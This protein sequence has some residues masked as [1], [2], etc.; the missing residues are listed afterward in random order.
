VT[1]TETEPCPSSTESVPFPST[2]NVSNG[3][4]SN[5]PTQ[6]SQVIPKPPLSSVTPGVV[7]VGTTTPVEASTLSTGIKSTGITITVSCSNCAKGPSPTAITTAAHP[8]GVTITTVAHPSGV[9]NTTH[10][11]SPSTSVLVYT[12]VAYRPSGFLIHAIMVALSI[13]VFLNAL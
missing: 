4:T 9:T 1:F 2:G 11:V 3:T 7:K 6:T 12:G 10:P 13:L 5:L 8:S